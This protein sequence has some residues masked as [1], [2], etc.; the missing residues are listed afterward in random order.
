MAEPVDESLSSADQEP[1]ALHILAAGS[2]V[3]LDQ[4]RT[5]WIVGRVSF[6]GWRGDVE[7]VG[8]G[9]LSDAG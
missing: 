4:Q 5:G 6:E 9:G 1:A 7:T 2:N 3:N 8:T